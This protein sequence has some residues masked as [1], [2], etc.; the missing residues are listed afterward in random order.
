MINVYCCVSCSSQIIFL[1]IDLANYWYFASEKLHWPS[2]ILS[3]VVAKWLINASVLEVEKQVVSG[4]DLGMDWQFLGL[5]LQQS[6]LKCCKLIPLVY[7]EVWVQSSKWLPDFWKPSVGNSGIGSALGTWRSWWD[8]NWNQLESARIALPGNLMRTKFVR[9]TK[10]FEIERLEFLQLITRSKSSSG[11][12]AQQEGEGLV[13]AICILTPFSTSPSSLFS[14]SF[15][16]WR[17][18]ETWWI[19]KS[20]Q[21]ATAEAVKQ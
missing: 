1:S 2:S 21:N 10:R 20:P 14:W 7:G 15:Q 8:K 5:R 13:V 17:F 9:C 6:S 16:R 11:T 12:C 19:T 4:W 18:M 3:C